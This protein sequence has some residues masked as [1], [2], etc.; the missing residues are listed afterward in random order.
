MGGTYFALAFRRGLTH[1]LPAML[2]LPV[3]VTAVILAWD[4]WVRRR[5]NPGAE[6]ARAGPVFA[7]ALVGVL[8]HP[9]L[10][11][12][13]TYGMRWWLPFDATWSYGDALFIIDPWIWLAL[14][15]AV[16][17]SSTWSRGWT[18]AWI[19]LAVAASVLVLFAVPAARVP[20][21]IGLATVV[22][23][24]A[25][26]RPAT[27]TGR[28][29]TAAVATGLACVYVLTFVSLDGRAR[30]AVARAAVDAGL[31][32]TDLM[33]A[34]VRGNP[35]VSDV[36]VVTPDGY[37]PGVHRL[38]GEPAVELFP[39]RMLPL[40]IAPD[41]IGPVVV[42]DVIARARREPEVRDYLVWSRYPFVRVERDADGWRV[43]H[44]DARYDDVLEAGGL[45]G[46]E[47]RL[48]PSP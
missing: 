14:G 12:M 33:V 9:V 41:G 23:L 42:Q 45:A 10:D 18:T 2:V 15:G 30:A 7:L 3:L 8:T 32:V 19:V 43:L 20:W 13:N 44:G 26:G 6:P 22:G 21:V 27:P 17:L 37:G 31:T 47:V 1:G 5:S 16:F 36:E 38:L 25:T 29:R 24:R 46:V 34:P 11:W 35:L 39:E 4:R 28:R 48:P 40:V